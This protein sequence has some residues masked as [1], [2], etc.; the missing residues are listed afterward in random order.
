MTDLFDGFDLKGLPLS[1]RVVMSATTRTLATE[2]D[3]PT[4]A[5]RDYY[6]QRGS[7]ELIVT[8]CTQ[9][10]DQG[11][12]PRSRRPSGRPDRRMARNNRCTLTL[13]PQAI[14][15]SRMG[16]EVA[17]SRIPTSVGKQRS[18]DCQ[19]LEQ[20]E[21]HCVQ[22]KG[23]DDRR[24]KQSGDNGNRQR[25]HQDAVDGQ[26]AEN[27]QIDDRRDDE[28]STRPRTPDVLPLTGYVKYGLGAEHKCHHSHG[29]QRLGAET[30][31]EFANRQTGDAKRQ[32]DHAH[33]DAGDREIA[34]VPDIRPRRW[35]YIVGR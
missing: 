24:G 19:A 27:R 2:D 32:V 9:V 13:L 6:V 28:P 31:C 11:H 8:E 30:D 23:K 29:A 26:D 20:R 17:W 1:N 3:V 4:D 10:S 22:D 5:M 18:C 25:G 15:R 21:L 14:S 7:A 33:D 34:D 12:H 16:S 35:P